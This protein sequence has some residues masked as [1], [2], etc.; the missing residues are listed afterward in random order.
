M[1]KA[2]ERQNKEIGF[3]VLSRQYLFPQDIVDTVREPILVLDSELRVI[4]ANRPF[5]HN[6]K[7]NKSETLGKYLFELGS[8]Q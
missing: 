6:F 8:G 2:K 3:N 7:V 1:V 5:Y 4:Y